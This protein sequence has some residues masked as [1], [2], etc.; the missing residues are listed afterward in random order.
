MIRVEELQGYEGM[1]R[2]DEGKSFSIFG[3]L[4]G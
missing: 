3:L 1:E 2:R 4:M